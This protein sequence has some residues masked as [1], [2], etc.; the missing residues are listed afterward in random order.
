[1]SARAHGGRATLG[2]RGAPTTAGARGPRWAL[3]AVDVGREGHVQVHDVELGGVGGAGGEVV[4]GE[5]VLELDHLAVGD[6]LAHLALELVHVILV[7]GT[8]LIARVLEQPP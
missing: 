1:M 5:D 4:L 7:F 2:G 3:T 6:G 8:R